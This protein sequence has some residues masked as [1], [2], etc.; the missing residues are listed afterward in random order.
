MGSVIRFANAAARERC[1]GG[2]AVRSGRTALGTVPPDWSQALIY[3]LPEP[4]GCR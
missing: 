4:P 1:M 3:P 2:G